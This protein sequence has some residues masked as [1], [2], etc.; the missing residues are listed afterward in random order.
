MD[1]KFWLLRGLRIFLFAALFLTAAVF[2]TQYLWNWLVPELF[3]G[4]AIGL[5]Q[6]V[7]LL[8]LSRILFGGFRGGGRPGA[9]AQRRK[10][11]QQRMAGRLEHLSPEEREKFRLQM[12]QRCGMGW[13]R[14]PETAAEPKMEQ[15][16]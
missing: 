9:W 8:V 14:R 2:L 15:P 12:Q 11:W 7:G 16:A 13:M 1:R 3:H 4:P 5:G 6:T 10:A